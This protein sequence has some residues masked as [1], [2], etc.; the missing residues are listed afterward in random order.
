MLALFLLHKSCIK[1]HKNSNGMY[2]KIIMRNISLF[3]GK[4]VDL[5][6][7]KEYN[8]VVSICLTEH[9]RNWQKNKIVKI[10]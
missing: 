4:I 9:L 7:G 5:I 8:V 10:K 1:I 3:R 2:E 6:G